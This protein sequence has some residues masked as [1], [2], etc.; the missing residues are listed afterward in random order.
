EPLRDLS[1]RD[2]QALAAKC[3]GGQLYFAEAHAIVV[4]AARFRRNYWKYRNH[5]KAYRSVLLDAGNLAQTLYLSA[6]ELGL[7]AFI[8][9]GVNEL[10]IERELELDPMEEGVLAACGF[11]VRSAERREVEFDP[12]NGV[13]PSHATEPG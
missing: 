11:G 6:T 5:A 8:T 3:L 12:P 1:G 10:D 13:Y 4:L 9:A 7:G 2:T